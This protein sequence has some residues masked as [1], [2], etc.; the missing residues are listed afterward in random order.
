MVVALMAATAVLASWWPAR[1]AAQA[2]PM[3]ALRHE[4]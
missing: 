4:G 2:D 3:T 1:R